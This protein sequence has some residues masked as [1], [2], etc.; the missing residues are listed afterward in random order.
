MLPEAI[1]FDLDDTL[2]EDDHV[3]EIA[4]NRVGALFA[5]KWGLFPADKFSERVNYIRKHSWHEAKNNSLALIGRIDYSHIRTMVVKKALDELGCHYQDDAVEEIVRT[6]SITKLQLTKYV[7]DAENTLQELLDR[8]VKLV[9]LTNGEGPEQRNKIEKLGISRFFTACLV[10]GDLGYGKPDSR[11]FELALKQ[12]SVKAKQ[13][14]MVG[15]R[16]DYDIIGAQQSGIYSVWCDYG[17]MGLPENSS[18]VPN[19]I[20]NSI[21]ELLTI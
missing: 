8:K 9:L 19:K 13:V 18:V 10:E 12:L 1:F 6:F 15:D 14:W 7:P 4:W 20:I 3:A 21:T 16:L 2:L 5:E 17:K 11:F